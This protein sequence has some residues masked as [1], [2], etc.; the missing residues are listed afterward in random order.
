MK[1][2]WRIALAALALLAGGGSALAG[3]GA[4]QSAG[5]WLR[6]A[7]E[8]LAKRASP[9]DSAS[10]R[11]AGGVV[12]V[13]YSSPRVRGRKIMGGLVPF[14][15]PWRLGANEATAIHLT[16][17]ATIAGVAVSPGWYSLYVT[18][19]E[20]EWRVVVNRQARRWGIPIDQGVRAADVGSA[21][22]PVG[23]TAGPVE[24]LT[25]AFRPTGAASAD[26]VIEWERT[27]VRIPV[28]LRRRAG[29]ER[30]PGR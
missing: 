28:V 5:C 1:A 13:C 7:H 23:R 6:D 10:I 3:Q 30:Q 4:G 14:G 18:P 17:P 20:R 19:G 26:L 24:D 15:E 25:L 27:S 12:K 11:L 8:D 16:S 21:A 9:L 22:V 29:T 2:S